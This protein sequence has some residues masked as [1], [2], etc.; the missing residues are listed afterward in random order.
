MIASCCSRQFG[1]CT[2]RSCEMRLVRHDYRR[3]A[4]AIIACVSAKQDELSME[5][6]DWKINLSET[7]EGSRHDIIVGSCSVRFGLVKVSYD[8]GALLRHSRTAHCHGPLRHHPSNPGDTSRSNL[9]LQ[10][11]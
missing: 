8:T 1:S 9:A 4:A 2:V 5:D 11:I 7:Q 3:G 10:F 6:D